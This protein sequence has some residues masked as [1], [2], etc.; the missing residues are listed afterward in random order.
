[1]WRVFLFEPYPICCPW[2][3]RSAL[4]CVPDLSCLSP[5]ALCSRPHLL[6]ICY[7]HL[8]H[9]LPTRFH[10][11]TLQALMKCP[12]LGH[13]S[14]TLEATSH[15]VVDTLW[16]P[17]R[18]VYAHKPVTLVAVEPGCLCLWNMSDLSFFSGFCAPC[19]PADRLSQSL[20][21]ALSHSSIFLLRSEVG[22]TYSS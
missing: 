3:Q 11:S 15:A 17:P 22:V 16:L 1:M 5:T 10:T 18:W 21:I 6:D 19:E 12:Y 8:L 2:Y 4:H 13:A 7:F 9:N 20:Y 14:L